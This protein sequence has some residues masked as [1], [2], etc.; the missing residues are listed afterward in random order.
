MAG[1]HPLVRH[2][3]PTTLGVDRRTAHVPRAAFVPHAHERNLALIVDGDR[4][5]PGFALRQVLAADLPVPSGDDLFAWAQ[6]SGG[7]QSLA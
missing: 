3:R 1:R 6:G 7:N 4:T 2:T 5:G